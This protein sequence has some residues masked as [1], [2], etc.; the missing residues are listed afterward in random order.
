MSGRKHPLSL[1]LSEDD[2]PGRLDLNK[3]AERGRACIEAL[4]DAEE[5]PVHESVVT[6]G[7]RAGLAYATGVAER[8]LNGGAAGEARDPE[9][10]FAD[11]SYRAFRA[12]AESPNLYR[13]LLARRLPSDV[14]SNIWSF[15]QPSA[16]DF[17]EIAQEARRTHANFARLSMHSRRL[18]PAWFA[19]D[20]D[21]TRRSSALVKAALCDPEGAA[22][23]FLEAYAT[24]VEI[25][26]CFL[27]EALDPKPK[28]GISQRER[29]RSAARYFAR[30]IAL[31]RRIVAPGIV[32][33]DRSHCAAIYPTIT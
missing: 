9:I 4:Y 17:E 29:F 33:R 5:A 23:A 27:V 20:F 11:R 31:A 30:R 16:T 13:R 12:K 32:S 19:Y 8:R 14:V 21:R 2:R 18:L 6:W 26:S 22:S 7:R 28:K 15:L 1:L 3:H 25:A 10:D 24:G